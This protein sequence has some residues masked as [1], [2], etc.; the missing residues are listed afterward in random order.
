MSRNIDKAKILSPNSTMSLFKTAENKKK[1]GLFLLRFPVL[2]T[3]KLFLI[4][5]HINEKI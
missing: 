4:E 5:L 3:I 2:D 1:A